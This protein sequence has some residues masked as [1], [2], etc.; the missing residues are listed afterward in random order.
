M[1]VKRKRSNK[2][3]FVVTYF[4]LSLTRIRAN[5][6]ELTFFVYS[7]YV[8]A[9]IPTLLYFKYLSEFTWILIARRHLVTGHSVAEANSKLFALRLSICNIKVWQTLTEMFFF[10]NKADLFYII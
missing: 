5:L 3:C 10:F 1:F 9:Y 6:K 4:L 7:N 8:K 2:M